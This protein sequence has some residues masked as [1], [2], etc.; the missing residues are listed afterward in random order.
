MS[1]PTT[2]LGLV[3]VLQVSGYG[4][5]SWLSRR[6]VS[7]LPGR[8][9]DGR[10][11]Y[12]FEIAEAI[13]AQQGGVVNWGKWKSF[14]TRHLGRLIRPRNSWVLRTADLLG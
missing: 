9:R 14:P 11:G 4:T 5:N 10:V 3:V 12:R 1:K 7:V 8:G 6:A 2:G 13:E